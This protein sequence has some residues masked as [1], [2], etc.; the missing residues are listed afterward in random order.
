MSTA[1]LCF[2]FLFLSLLCQPQTCAC[3]SPADPATAT[4]VRYKDV[5]GTVLANKDGMGTV[6]VNNN[7]ARD[8][9]GAPGLKNKY[10]VAVEKY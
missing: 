5:M 8:T 7:K 9:A 4:V 1:D 3:S 2:L 6:V 10:H